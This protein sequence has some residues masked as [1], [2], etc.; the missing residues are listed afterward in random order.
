[1]NQAKSSRFVVVNPKTKTLPQISVQ[2]S[3]STTNLSSRSRPSSSPSTSQLTSKLIPSNSSGNL[4]QFTSTPSVSSIYRPSDHIRAPPS[5]NPQISS[6]PPSPSDR[7]IVHPSPPSSPGSIDQ[8]LLLTKKIEELERSLKTKDKEIQRL[9]QNTATSVRPSSSSITRT[10]SQSSQTDPS[11]FARLQTASDKTDLEAIEI[12]RKQLKDAISALERQVMTEKS[13]ERK[14]AEEAVQ[15]RKEEAVRTKEEMDRKEKIKEREKQLSKEISELKQ[16]I[17]QH[18]STEQAREQQLLEKE[19]ELNSRVMVLVEERISTMR[20]NMQK[21]LQRKEKEMEQRL[22]ELEIQKRGEAEVERENIG[23]QNQISL[24]SK[25]KIERDVEIAQLKERL[26]SLRVELEREQGER[27]QSQKEKEAELALL[28]EQ[29]KSMEE[30]HELDLNR[31]KSMRTEMDA[32]LARQTQMLEE[33][34]RIQKEKKEIERRIE[35]L[36]KEHATPKPDTA[37][38]F[39]LDKTRKEL[40]V[41]QSEMELKEALLKEM[42]EKMEETEDQYLQI[43]EK[44]KKVSNKMLVI[45]VKSVMVEP[46]PELSFEAERWRKERQILQEECDK[47][48]RQ[49]GEELLRMR[50]QTEQDRVENTALR[51]RL[52]EFER[53]QSAASRTRTAAPSFETALKAELDAMR[54]GYEQRL[55]DLNAQ[56]ENTH[57]SHF[58]TLT[59]LKAAHS[60]EVR[61]LERKLELAHQRYLQLEADTI[62]QGLLSGTESDAI[63][64]ALPAGTT[65]TA[66]TMVADG[67]GG[68]KKE[69]GDGL[70]DLEEIKA[71]LPMV[72][73]K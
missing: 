69:E 70:I 31:I 8:T 16:Q 45:D 1:M 51:A 30:D 54:R 72:K 40:K 13:K 68:Y 60:E 9:K 4:T 17:E 35:E 33:N 29:K 46:K 71:L 56:I 18:R 2:H 67:K 3:N 58:N 42:K 57:N 21:E 44:L 22:E 15:K 19:R 61:R 50:V 64:G 36:K 55:I 39:E 28:E 25:E 66:S 37:S 11:Y 14:R 26:D 5:P 62:A 10:S 7:S 20:A 38:Q 49:R 24:L 34:E 32:I 48:N 65:I 12:E 73:G 53:R 47:L 23:L 41:V 6:K 27:E 63:M 43:L 52:N 59:S